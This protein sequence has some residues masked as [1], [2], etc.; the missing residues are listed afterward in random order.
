MTTHLDGFR[1]DESDPRWL[2]VY[3]GHME[4]ADFA[5]ILQLLAMRLV[6]RAQGNR[7]GLLMVQEHHDHEHEHDEER[8]VEGEA[9]MTKAFNDFRRDYRDLVRQHCTAYARVFA[10]EDLVE[11]YGGVES[12]LAQIRDHSDLFSQYNFGIRGGVFSDE[13]EAKAWLTAQADLPPLVD[14]PSLDPDALLDTPKRVGLFYGSTTGVTQ[15]VAEQIAK[16]WEDAGQLPLVP[17][18]I[19]SMKD[20]SAFLTYD[21][22]I[23][24]IP[25]WNVGELQD[26]WEVVFPQLD[27]LDF[28]G[29]QVALFGVGDARGYPYNFL[30]AMGFLGIKV[31]S[32]G[33]TLVGAWSTEGY[34]F[35][36][37]EGAENGSF[38]GLGIDEDNQ[39]KLT[40]GRV[41]AWVQQVIREF[42]LESV[43]A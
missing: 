43:T 40:A 17:I 30:D 38:M 37:S 1:V 14:T 23:L 9:I 10:P 2:V 8:D 12:G 20:I 22:L 6:T 27:K 24:G 4:I 34:D 42:A 16:A 29:K 25:T 11:W 28:H 33:A 18:N 13:Q 39:P 31:R 26:D 41:E 5:Q 35:E 3:T 32:R 19:T 15:Y 21:R 36:M 7:F